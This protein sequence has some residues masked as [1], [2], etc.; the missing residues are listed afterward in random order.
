M[1]MMHSSKLSGNIK[2]FEQMSAGNTGQRTSSHSNTTSMGCGNNQIKQRIRSNGN[3][4]GGS[5]SA[6]NG[7]TRYQVGKTGTT[8]AAGIRNI[9][10]SSRLQE[11]FGKVVQGGGISNNNSSFVMHGKYNGLH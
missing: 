10:I 3:V 11:P 2:S 7:Q 8:T 4:G 5:G 1:S 6:S 9:E